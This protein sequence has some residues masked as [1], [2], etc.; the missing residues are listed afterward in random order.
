MPEI[1]VTE[2]D[3]A[4]I[5]KLYKDG[6]KNF[7]AERDIA[8]DIT[9]SLPECRK[10]VENEIRRRLD[11]TDPLLEEAAPTRSATQYVPKENRLSPGLV[12]E[13]EKWEMLTGDSLYDDRGNPMLMRSDSNGL[14]FRA[15]KSMLAN[16]G[17]VASDAFG[18]PIAATR[19]QAR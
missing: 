17:F 3:L 15:N 8:L 10:K 18:N 5:A 13:R 7:C 19:N 12:G 9:M 1:N 2:K 14:V 16:T 4:R 11:M 6:L